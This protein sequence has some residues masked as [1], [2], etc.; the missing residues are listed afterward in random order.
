MVILKF[1]LM[2]FDGLLV[3][4]ESYYTK[5]LLLSSGVRF[6]DDYDI[7]LSIH[8]SWLGLELL[9]ADFEQRTLILISTDFRSYVLMKTVTAP[10]RT[11]APVS[12]HFDPKPFRTG[13]PRDPPKLNFKWGSA[14]LHS[15]AIILTG[16]SIEVK[17]TISKYHNQNYCQ[18]VLHSKRLRRTVKI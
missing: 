18:R 11:T 9:F 15:L 5:R 4:L 10:H 8:S 13:T 1:I 14:E 17:R 7:T 3:V 16:T 2:F 12:G 6:Y